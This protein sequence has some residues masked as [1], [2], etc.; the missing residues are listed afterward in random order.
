MRMA[1]ADAGRG[2]RTGGM[3]ERRFLLPYLQLAVIFAR[4]E[5][6]LGPWEGNALACHSSSQLFQRVSNELSGKCILCFKQYLV[7]HKFN[8][9]SEH[10]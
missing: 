1:D 5:G 8:L 6:D 3:E 4:Q 9:G 7:T 10:F 2:R